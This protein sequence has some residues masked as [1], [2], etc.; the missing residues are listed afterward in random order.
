MIEELNALAVHPESH[1]RA[2]LDAA[3]THCLGQPQRHA[4]RDVL[5]PRSPAQGDTQMHRAGRSSAINGDWRIVCRVTDPVCAACGRGP[6]ASSALAQ[7]T[8]FVGVHP[9]EHSL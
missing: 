1:L 9:V 3:R 8:V 2:S 6:L 5:R 4:P 7:K